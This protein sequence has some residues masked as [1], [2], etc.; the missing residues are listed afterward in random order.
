[1]NGIQNMELENMSEELYKLNSYIQ[2][3][4]N[5]GEDRYSK[6]LKYKDLIKALFLLTIDFVFSYIVI[7]LMLLF[8]GDSESFINQYVFGNSFV[9]LIFQWFI[10]DYQ[11]VF[12]E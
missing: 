12:L 11:K 3:V 2:V 5:K 9:Y 4:L 8:N 6:I 10:A 1:M 7:L